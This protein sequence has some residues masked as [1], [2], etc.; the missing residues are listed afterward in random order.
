M[1][2]GDSVRLIT[3]LGIGQVGTVRPRRCK[4]KRFVVRRLLGVRI[5]CPPLHER[6]LA[7]VRSGVLRTKYV[8]VFP[9]DCR[10]LYWTDGRVREPHDNK[11]SIQ[12]VRS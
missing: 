3:I 10:A 5:Q 9:I 7:L 6:V 1:V 4:L 12:D 11:H 8:C 2:G